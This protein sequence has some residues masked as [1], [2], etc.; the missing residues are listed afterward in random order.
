MLNNR[1]PGFT[2]IELLVVIAIIALLATFAVVSLNSARSRARDSKRLSDIKQMH[3]ALELYFNVYN[4][5]PIATTAATAYSVLS[6]NGSSGLGDFLSPIPQN[7]TPLNNDECNQFFIESMGGIP[8][9]YIYGSQP[10]GSE[11]FFFYCLE[12]ER[13]DFN[14]IGGMPAG[15]YF[16][17]SG[18]MSL[19]SCPFVYSWNGKEYVFDT[20]ALTKRGLKEWKGPEISKLSSLVGQNGEYKIKIAEK[21][22]ETSYFDKISLIRVE[23][24]PGSEVYFDQNNDFQV[25]NNKLLPYYAI[26]DT[27]KNVL[28]I[29]SEKG[30]MW[31]SEYNGWEGVNLDDKEGDRIADSNEFEDLYRT[32]ELRFQKPEEAK[33]VK[34]Q[35]GHQ[36]QKPAALMATNFKSSAIE[37]D[38]K[39]QWAK[40][41]T[42]VNWFASQVSTK[43]QV[44]KGGNG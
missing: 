40:D 44:W 42:I 34:L 22:P 32:L 8:P 39:N 4:R 9:E 6:G 16:A 41:G 27:G 29:L 20:E 11:Y 21:V 35:I 10:D 7:P 36:V 24:R 31:N 23:H 1:K 33:I 15:S 17:G 26:D 14:T 2:L 19:S 3:T 25:L 30:Q 38:K 37:H 28:E 12:N 18:G 13:D 43:L 5:Y